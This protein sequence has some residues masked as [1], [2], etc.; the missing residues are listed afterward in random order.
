[1]QLPLLVYVMVPAY[2]ANMVPVLVRWIPWAAP[3]DFG[4]AVGGKRVLGAHK[5]WRGFVCG[6]VLG[7]LAMWLLSLLYWPFG[8]SA[9]R[10]GLL[11]SVGA[12]LGDAVKSFFKRRM[13]VRPG[14]PWVPFDQVDY[15]IGALLLG[16]VVFFPGWQE[17]VLVVVVSLI[18]HITVNH[19]GYYAGIRDVKW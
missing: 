6:V 17:A 14:R 13:S 16:S 3:M 8:F 12:L 9:L 1:M 19:L 11:A 5:T 18:G 2:V 10:W 4:A 15:S 7:A